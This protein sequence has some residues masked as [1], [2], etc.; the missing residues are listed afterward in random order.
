MQL[1]LKLIVFFL[2][3][4]TPTSLSSKNEVI[5]SGHS[6]N[7]AEAKDSQILIKAHISKDWHTLVLKY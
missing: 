1:S 3:I 2:S 7:Q 4:H 6:A 5:I